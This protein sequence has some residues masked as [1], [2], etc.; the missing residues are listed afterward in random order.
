VIREGA[1]PRHT[2]A[3][4]RTVLAL[5]AVLGAAASADAQDVC[6]GTAPVPNAQLASFPVVT[7]L[8]GR[9]LLVTAPPGDR[10]RLFIVEQNGLI[11]IHRRGDPTATV[12]TFLDITDRVQAASSLNE[13]GLLGLAFDPDYDT[14]GI[15]YVNYTEGTINGPWSTVV[16]RFSVVPGAPDTADPDSEERLLVFPQPQSN[17]NG[18]QLF[19]GA[20]GFLYIATGDG[21]GGGDQHGTCGNGQSRTTLL[22]KM[23]RLDVAGIDPTSLPPDCGGAGAGYRVP[24]GNPFAAIGASACGEIWID[25]LRNP[26]RSAFDP[27]NGDL[28]IADVGQDCWEEVDVLSPAAQPGAN[29]GWRSMEGLHCFSSGSGNCNPSAV[30]CSGVPTC[31]DPSLLLPV[32]E[33]SHSQGCSITGGAVYRGCQLPDWA[34]IYFYGDFCSGFIR[35]FRFSGGAV[36]EATDRTAALDPGATLGNSLTSFGQDA[37]GELYI[38]DRDGIVRRIGPR[39]VDL[40]VS[41]PGEAA[42][43]L[44]GPQSWTWGDL[45]FASM[46]PVSFYRVWRGAPGGVFH[47]RFTSASPQWPGGDPDTPPVGGLFAYVVTAVDASGA[48]TRPGIAATSFLRDACP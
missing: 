16:S 20:D 23:L 39:F 48:E 21:G 4:P 8:T 30:A 37:Q 14:S 24:S 18:G 47:C 27:A 25:G 5:L 41:A 15:F 1:A 35:S 10:D 6:S 9:P 45:A 19:F 38:V 31:G 13:M 28:Y 33:Y 7:G 11:R 32:L 44:L 22:G 3:A 12:G 2:R 26:W 43:L 17:H 29:L 46:R 42:P 34:G 36:L 40:E